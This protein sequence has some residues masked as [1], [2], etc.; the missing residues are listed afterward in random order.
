ME[1]Y[2]FRKADSSMNP[3]L[4]FGGEIILSIHD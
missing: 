4:F 1:V 2:Q 3:R